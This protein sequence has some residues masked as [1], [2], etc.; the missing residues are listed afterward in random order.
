VVSKNPAVIE[1]YMGSADAEL[2]G[3]H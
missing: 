3:A 1:A 2:K